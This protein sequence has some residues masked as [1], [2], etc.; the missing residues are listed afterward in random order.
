MVS[1]DEQN[2]YR[3]CRIDLDPGR[4]DWVLKPF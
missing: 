3:L 2:Y 4:A 1:G